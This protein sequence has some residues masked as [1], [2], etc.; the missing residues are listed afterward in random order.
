MPGGHP[1]IYFTP[2][3]ARQGRLKSKKAYRERNIDEERRKS[4]KRT[5]RVLKRTKEEDTITARA[6]MND[7]LSE[8]ISARLMQDVIMSKDG[9]K[10][11]L[12]GPQW[13]KMSCRCE[14]EL[15]LNE[16]WTTGL[17][18]SEPH[19]WQSFLKTKHEQLVKVFQDK[20]LD[21]VSAIAEPLLQ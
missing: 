4:R 18:I 13:S 10:S 14:L 2:E 19:S 8:P 9:G 15:S 21:A 17:G 12:T 11:S 7:T 3:E 16:V 1:R 6:H 5:C 20:G